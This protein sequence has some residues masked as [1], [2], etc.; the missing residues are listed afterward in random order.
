MAASRTRVVMAASRI[1][2][3]GTSLP[4]WLGAVGAALPP[5][6]TGYQD[7]AAYF[8]RQ[9]HV[10]ERWG[11]HLI[12]S[13]FGTIETA[14]FNYARPIGTAMPKP[15]GALEANV[16]PRALRAGSWRRE[17]PLADA[18]AATQL[19]YPTVNRQT[20]GDRLANASVSPA[21]SRPPQPEP[22]S[23]PSPASPTTPSAI[24]LKSP[25]ARPAL[26]AATASEQHDE[27]TAPTARIDAVAAASP[28]SSPP[29]P[30]VSDATNAAES[31][32]PQAEPTSAASATASEQHD[33]NAAPAGRIDAVDAASP[34]S[35]PPKL[36]VP[37]AADA[38]PDY[39]GTSGGDE[40]I[41]LGDKPTDITASSAAAA[42]E[43]QSSALAFIDDDAADRN[44]QVY[45]GSSALGAPSGLQP[46]APGAG[47][48]SVPP[49]IGSDDSGIKLSALEGS[50]SGSDAGGETIAG[51]D[52]PARLESPAQRLHLAGKERAKAEKCLADAV[53]FEARGEPLRGQ[54]AV[55]QV[56]MNRVFSGYYP[57][58]V[59]SVVFQNASHHLACQ[60]TFAC[61][62][63]NLHRIDEPDM[64]EQA[65]R[66]AKDTL[67]GKIW[68]ADIGHA[69]HYHAYWVHPRWVHEMKRLD[70]L[71]VHTFYRPRAW[72]NGNDEPVWGKTPGSSKAGTPANT[73][74]VA[75]TERTADVPVGQEPRSKGRS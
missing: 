26:P 4:F 17:L 18:A 44:A 52:D 50:E 38:E 39:A 68:L 15:P 55:A 53:Y 74:A 60:F 30:R 54:E 19:R 11:G 16:D 73:S 57:N 67:D 5:T 8:A 6:S 24:E 35:S 10:S 45:F 31:R 72:G 47:P 46:W 65:K 13:P 37:D 42:M 61:E 64:W 7:L 22:M 33:E 29:R 9:S 3:A 49:S 62:G 21:P 12:A 34:A 75:P 63:K 70:K 20:K 43:T 27:S 40:F 36:R 71:G 32:P 1:R 56:V 66:I 41:D 69:T 59:C 51:K 23:A 28:T 58:N 48:V 14:T 2:S 25:P